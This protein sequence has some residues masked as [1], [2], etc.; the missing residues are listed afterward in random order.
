[1]RIA[2]EALVPD[3]LLLPPVRSEVA[4]V[5]LLTLLEHE[6]KVSPLAFSVGAR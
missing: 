5:V 4:S 6:R 1:M 3:R 2:G